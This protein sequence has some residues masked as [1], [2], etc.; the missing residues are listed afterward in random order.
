MR[1]VASRGAQE[2]MPID[3]AE[4]HLKNRVR[5]VEVEYLLRQ[6]HRERRRERDQPT[7]YVSHTR[8]APVTKSAEFESAELHVARDRK[9]PKSHG[10]LIA[11]S[12]QANSCY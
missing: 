10:R 5:W 7:A 1:P 12:D 11:L 8:F 9:P 6:P 2:N 3:K 4:H